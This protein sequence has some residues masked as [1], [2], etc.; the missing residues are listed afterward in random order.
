MKRKAAVL[1]LLLLAVSTASAQSLT[2]AEREKAVKHLEA[3]RD[4][5]VKSFEK[6]SDAQWNWKPAPEIWSV[7]ECAEHI[8]LSENA[9][10]QLLQDRILKSPAAPERKADVQGKDDAVL[11]MIPD[12]TEKFKAP[13]IIQ[14]KSTFTT[15]EELIKRF[16]ESRARLIEFMKTTDLDLRSHFAEHAVM[17]LLDA[18]QWVLLTSAHTERHTKQIAEVK[19]TEGFPSR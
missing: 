3:S 14:P 19:D 11:K 1:V 17:K 10:W 6:L 18:Y 9:L 4:A 5:F 8:A 15:R 13:E 7:A 12:R 2:A 16:T